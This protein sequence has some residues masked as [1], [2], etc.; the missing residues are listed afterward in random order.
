MIAES[1]AGLHRCTTSIAEHDFLPRGLACR[2]IAVTNRS[3]DDTRVAGGSSA[4][5]GLRE[6]LVLVGGA[7]FWQKRKGH[8]ATG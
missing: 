3:T 1:L 6:K 8:P 4:K 5:N 7:F 2:V